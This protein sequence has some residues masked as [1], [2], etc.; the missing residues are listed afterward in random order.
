MQ[1]I[2]AYDVKILFNLSE[3]K[4]DARSS[5]CLRLRKVVDSDMCLKVNES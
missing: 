5:D 4:V 2:Y 1:L 3:V